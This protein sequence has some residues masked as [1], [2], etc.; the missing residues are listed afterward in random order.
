MLIERFIGKAATQTYVNGETI[1]KHDPKVIEGKGSLVRLGLGVQTTVI[2]HDERL[3]TQDMPESLRFAI[4]KTNNYVMPQEFY[5][6]VG[7]K[8]YVTS[9]D[10]TYGID[11]TVIHYDKEKPQSGS[12]GAP[13]EFEVSLTGLVSPK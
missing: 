3:L 12:S 5:L 11:V 6:G 9:F 2:S 7:E 8:L 4:P 1:Y 10:T 13:K